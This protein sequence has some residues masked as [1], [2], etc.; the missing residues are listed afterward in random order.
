MKIAYFSPLSPLRSGIAEYS[1]KDLLPFLGEYCD[2]DIY[3]GDGYEPQNEYITK[4]F[5]IY[6]YK[7]LSSKLKEYDVILYHVG[8]S[9]SHEYIYECLQRYPGIVVLHDMFIHGLI[10]SCTLAK[11]DQKGYIAEFLQMYGEKGPKIAKMAMDC[12]SFVD[13]EFKYPLIKKILN[14]SKGIMVHS[15]YGRKIVL[16]DKADTFVKKIGFPIKSSNDKVDCINIRKNL[17][18]SSDALV[19]GSYG[20]ISGHKRMPVILRAFKKFHERY[21]KSVLLV[22]GEDNIRL[23]SMIKGYNVKHVIQTGYVTSKKMYEYMH[24]SDICINLRYPTAG[25]T[26]ASLLRLMDMDK[27]VIVSNIGWFSE[28]PDDC[29]IK[30]DINDY[31]EDTLLEFLYVLASDMI[32]REKIGKNAKTYIMKECDPYKVAEEYFMFINS[33]IKKQKGIIKEISDNLADIGIKETDDLIIR[34]VAE[35][36]KELN[37]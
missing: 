37:Y 7:K 3:I 33:I 22:V 15:R 14:S 31:E 20:F 13:I 9:Q 32:L 2:I 4:T 16:D 36:L 34:E 23:K 29:C 18:I 21:P 30:I 5:K 11:G 10:W 19:I 8:N 12:Q 28:L 6:N 17:G 35:I 27:P 26:S 24:I 1:E 25:E